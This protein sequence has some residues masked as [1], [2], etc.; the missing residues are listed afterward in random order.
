MRARPLL[1]CLLAAPAA[2]QPDAPAVFCGVYADAPACATGAVACVTC[3]DALGPPALNPYGLDL[4]PRIDWD[5]GFAA[6]LPDALAAVAALDSDGDGTAN[7]AEILSGGWP[8]S[9]DAVEPECT[10][11]GQSGNDGWLVGAWDPFLAWKRVTV[12]FCGRSPRYDEVQ[13]FDAEM[14]ALGWVRGDADPPGDARDDA[15]VLALVDAQLDAC[16]ASRYWDEVLTEIG[17][18]V[19]RPK[20]YNSDLYLLGNYEWD[21][22]LFA[23]ATSGDRDA[24]DLMAAQYLVVEEPA[25]SGL[26]VAIDEPRTA[27]EAYAQPLAAEDRFGLI[28]TRHSLAMNVMFAPVPRTLAAHWY[29]ELLGL[30]ISLSEGLF[31]VDEL[32]GAYDWAAPRDVDDK[33]VWQEECAGCHTTVDPLSYPW[34]RYN[35][36]DLEGDTTATLVADRATDV[37]PDIEGAIFGLAV[38]T[39][40]DWVAAAVA[41]DAFAA[42]VV[43][44]FW[45]WLYRRAPYACEEEEVEALWRGFRDGSYARV[46][47][48]APRGVEDMLRELVRGEAYATP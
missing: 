21:L 7:E 28:T 39:P 19:V 25:G 31:P 41:S 8:G 35:G 12:D 32:P 13:A 26:L 30:D 42:R 46:G 37:L 23:Y 14:A 17:V 15:A 22:R 2:A 43:E 27:T 10:P 34:A 38:E 33:G 48:A 1:L 44:L 40:A 36:I 11:Q 3:H 45:T 18:G 6:S 47:A 29:R 20:G 24:G 9:A 16:L 5:Q 4:S